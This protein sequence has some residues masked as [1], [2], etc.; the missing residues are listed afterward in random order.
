M[1]SFKKTYLL[2]FKF[3]IQNYTQEFL[4]QRSII[5]SWI[6]FIK[7][8]LFIVLKQQKSLEIINISSEHQNI[9]WINISAPSLGDSLMDLS[10]RVLLKDRKVDLFTDKKNAKLYEDDAVFSAIF[11][12]KK[13]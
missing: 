8:Y 13:R 4:Q 11:T 5:K 12:N 1:L 2:P 10:S 6:K 7:R 9:L 3:E